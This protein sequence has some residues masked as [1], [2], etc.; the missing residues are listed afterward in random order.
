MSYRGMGQAVVTGSA[1][2]WAGI[3]RFASSAAGG[4]GERFAGVFSAAARSNAQARYTASLRALAETI[5]VRPMAMM[6][7]AQ[8][9]GRHRDGLLAI[10]RFAS[11]QARS[12]GRVA[13]ASTVRGASPPAAVPVVNYSY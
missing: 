1:P 9:S 12:G 3:A 4:V 6:W 8:P 13:P 7:L 11:S 2:N 5:A 10:A